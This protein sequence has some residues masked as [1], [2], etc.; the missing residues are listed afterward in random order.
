MLAMMSV[1]EESKADDFHFKFPFNS[2]VGSDVGHL[3]DIYHL[4]QL[5]IAKLLWQLN[6]DIQRRQYRNHGD[7]RVST[8]Q[9][10]FQA[11]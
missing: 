9:Q 4:N 3:L 7:F 2:D 8:S 10:S 5:N 11:K 6:Y 1:T